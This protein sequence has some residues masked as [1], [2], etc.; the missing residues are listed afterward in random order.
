[1]LVDARVPATR[2]RVHL[3]RRLLLAAVAARATARQGRRSAG[4][5]LPPTAARRRLFLRDG[6]LA[7][8]GVLERRHAPL[9]LRR[10]TGPFPGGAGRRLERNRAVHSL[11]GLPLVRARRADLLRLWLGNPAARSRLPG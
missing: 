10:R 1:M 7:V 5:E 11:G 9:R 2:H 3:L 4:G 6:A 8:L